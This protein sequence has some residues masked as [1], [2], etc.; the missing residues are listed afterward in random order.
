MSMPAEAVGE[1][2]PAGDRVL[3]PEVPADRWWPG[4]PVAELRW[5]LELARLLADPVFHGRDVPRGDGRPVV[6]APGFLAGDWSL[7]VLRDWLWRIGYRPY[8]CGFVANVD[9]SNRALE[10]VER[11]VDSLHARH[12][13]RVALIGHSRGGHY[14]RALAA[15]RPDR[16]SHGISIGAD[17][18]R[19][20]GISTP[21]RVAVAGA[22]A[23]IR[24]SR[25][26]DA[27]DCFTIDCSCPFT[28]DYRIPF[29]EHAVRLTS[30]Y[31]KG[32][33]VVRWQGCIVPYASAVEVSGSHVGLVF[34]R[35]VYRAI[36]TALAAPER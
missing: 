28:R 27:E 15:R 35:K 3:P 10:H 31:S 11:R 36:A 20:V 9:C 23:G 14:V 22:R 32:D 18:R 8:T 12:G 13:R 30:I 1:P 5:Q 7:V 16:V 4:R 6:L 17:L 2:V 26:A 33:G 19:M 21:T 34:N 25:R 29:P 24:W